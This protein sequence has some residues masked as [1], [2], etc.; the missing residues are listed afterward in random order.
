MAFSMPQNKSEVL[1]M[2]SILKNEVFIILVGA[3]ATF[4]FTLEVTK[5]IIH[6]VMVILCFTSMTKSL[7]NEI[8]EKL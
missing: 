4:L 1:L 7:F 3:G 5:S 2:Y 8:K 6:F